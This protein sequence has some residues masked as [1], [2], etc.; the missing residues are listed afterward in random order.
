MVEVSVFKKVDFTGCTF[1]EGFP[2]A[3]LV[4]PM[5]IGYMIG[6]L[7]MEYVGY[8]SG[9]CFPP[10]IS[11]HE[12]MPMPPARIYYSS[13]YKIAVL[14]TEAAPVSEK[15]VHELVDA[16]YGFVQ[17]KKFA[18]IVSISGVPTDKPNNSDVFAV[19]SKKELAERITAAG[20]K[21]VGE[22]VAAGISALLIMRAALEGFDDFNILVP[23]DPRI[24]DPI[25]AELALKGLNRLIGIDIDTDELDKE[26]K[27]VE[28]RIKAMLKTSKDSAEAY[29]KGEGPPIFA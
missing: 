15:A 5:S 7:G 11:I 29:P 4:G 2:G 18:K 8:L 21:K 27:M 22:G 23:V 12:N 24:I 6:K 13:K 20:M 19:A 14:F 10:I 1:V 26:A 25:Y 16:L 9:E 28:S 17:E 3:G